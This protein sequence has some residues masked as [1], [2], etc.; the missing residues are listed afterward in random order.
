MREI[1]PH[2]ADIRLK[3]D[4]PDR[5]SLFREALLGITEILC[6][7]RSAE[8]TRERQ[9]TID[10]PDITLLLVDFLNEALT[11]VH[12]DRINYEEVEF[13]ELGSTRL[14]ARLRGRPITRW[15]RDVKAVTYHEAE[16]VERDGV[17]S[18]MIVL[19]I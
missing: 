4:A 18:T 2:T 3:V 17:W 15:R 11:L 6:Q 10:A 8:T 1:V 9:I 5:Q 14:D 13:R 19:D 16:V 12:V 7:S